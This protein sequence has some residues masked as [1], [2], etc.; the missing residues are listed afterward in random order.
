[1]IGQFIAVS[2]TTTELTGGPAKKEYRVA[3]V[4][5]T[6]VPVYISTGSFRSFVYDASYR[7]R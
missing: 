1:M 7:R 2:N 5:M 6:D 3:P 4:S